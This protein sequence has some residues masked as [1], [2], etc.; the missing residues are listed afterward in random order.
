MFIHSIKINIFLQCCTFPNNLLSF[1]LSVKLLRG[2]AH[3]GASNM[4]GRK[5]GVAKLTKDVQKMAMSSHCLGHSTSLSMRSIDD[6]T[7]GM[8]D[9][10]DVC[11]EI[12]KLTKFIPKRENMLEDMKMREMTMAESHED[13][14][15]DDDEI[16]LRNFLQQDGLYGM[17]GSFEQKTTTRL[18]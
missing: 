8:R 2:Q 9:F 11:M 12:V 4:L 15:K 1:K 17:R 10:M 7:R 14:D 5:S 18:C 13:L 3:D 16:P 6:V